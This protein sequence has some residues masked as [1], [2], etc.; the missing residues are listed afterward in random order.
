M[1][2]KWRSTETVE[3]LAKEDLH[4][5]VKQH[6]LIFRKL[7][8][9]EQL[10]RKRETKIQLAKKRRSVYNQMSKSIK[11]S[12]T[13][14]KSETQAYKDQPD[15]NQKNDEDSNGSSESE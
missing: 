12:R 3:E 1:K 6:N 13:G 4:E 9:H 14:N 5:D 11:K 7:S 15:E 2:T 10:R 8:L